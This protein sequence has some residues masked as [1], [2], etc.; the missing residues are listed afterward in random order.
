[1][2]HTAFSKRWQQEAA[3]AEY[4]SAL[5]HHLDVILQ[6]DYGLLPH[7]ATLAVLISTGTETGRKAGRKA[8]AS[9]PNTL[10]W[11]KFRRH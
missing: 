1:M 5:T 10:V 11:L 4:G 7:H 2:T 8:A 3:A 9:A 6:E